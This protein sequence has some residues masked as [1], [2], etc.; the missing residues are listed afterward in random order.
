VLTPASTGTSVL[1]RQYQVALFTLLAVVGLVLLIACANL[2]NLLL[3]RAT[4]RQQEFAVRLALGASRRRLVLQLLLERMLLAAAGAAL[5]LLLANIASHLLVQQLAPAATTT[6]PVV[7]DLALDRRVLAFTA[8]A[9][10]IT[11]LLFGL[12]P[13]FRSTDLSAH[14][15]MKGSGRS[16]ASGWT[17]FNLEQLL[18]ATQIALSLV[19]VFGASLFVRSFTSLATLD[20]GFKSDHVMLV[21]VN[22]RR[23]AYPPD[24]RLTLYDE[25]A[26]ALRAVPGVESVA[27]A[28]ITLIDNSSWINT[29]DVPGY[30]S[31]GEH[32]KAVH[33]N[34]VSPG[35]FRTLG[36]AIYAGRD[37]NSRDTL[38]APHV[39][40]V[41]QTFAKKFFGDRNP[42]GQHYREHEPGSEAWRSIDIIGVVQ[43]AK[44]ENLRDEI[45]PTAYVPMSQ[46]PAPGNAVN[47][48]VHTNGTPT[49]LVPSLSRAIAVVNNDIVYQFTA[50][51]AQIDA[52]LVQERLL[53]MLAGFFGVLALLV[54]G[55]GLYGVMWL[56]MTR[57]RREIGIR[58]ALGAQPATVI[59]MV[60]REVAII[61]AAGLIA[62]VAMGLITARLV[63]NL[64][65]GLTSTDA[66]TWLMA[67]TLLATV[68]GIAAYLPARHASRID[69]MIALRDE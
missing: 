10:L 58:L 48:L 65:F 33:M 20:P 61:T 23:A 46:I 4:A 7:L 25:V 28:M 26:D 47:I 43:D 52:S 27:S 54:A 39:A 11:A 63:T 36:S 44:Y 24:R 41:N 60:V 69:P 66:S 59:R 42:V 18:I 30:V 6:F 55:V 2:A 45:P 22:I 64:L 51:D 37:F 68:A 13:A 31:S 19:L 40:L 16:I 1:S 62:G 29:I 3:A 17:R 67:T 49:S 32:D 21:D 57:R 5:G 35:Y 15:L 9:T 53:A 34:A 38:Q 12:A 14:A 8:F 50:L 56:A